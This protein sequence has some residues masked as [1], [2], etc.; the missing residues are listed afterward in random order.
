MELV[1]ICPSVSSRVTLCK[2]IVT[3]VPVGAC[4][5]YLELTTAVLDVCVCV[6]CKRLCIGGNFIS[7]FHFQN[8]LIDEL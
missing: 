1:S 5:K 3:C 4:A 8:P 6:C 7:N 2:S